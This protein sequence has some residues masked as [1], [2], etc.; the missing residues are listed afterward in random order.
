MT[1]TRE[2]DHPTAGKLNMAEVLA[3]FT[4]TGDCPLKFTAYDG[5][6]AGNED[7]V[8]GLD[9]CSPRGTT[10]LATAPGELGIARAYI[11]GDL[12]TYGVHPGDPYELLRMLADRVDFK[13]PSARTLAQVIR[14]IGIEHLV[15]I[16][17]PPQETPPRWRRV[18]DGLLHSKTRDAEAIHHHYDVSNTFYEWLLGPSMTYTCAVYPHAGATLEEAQENKYRLIFDK[19]RLAPGDRL[20]DVGCGWGGMVRY[21]ARHGV[22]AIGVTLSG[23]QAKWAQ[24][25]IDKDGLS[26]LAEV[27]HCDYRDVPEA[28]FDAVSSIGLTEHIG[29]KNYPA[30]FEFLKSKLRT[31]GLLLNHCITRHDNKQTSFAGGFTDR[32]VFPDGELTGSGRILTEVQESGFEVLHQENFRHHY[33][34]TLRDWCRNLVEHWDIAV[35]EV[36]L[37]IAKV[38]GL[39]MAA[40]RVAFEQNNLQLHHVLAAN[41]ERRGADSLPLRPWW[42]P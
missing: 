7:A 39:Y 11:A 18:A 27:R 15:P 40:S 3:I 29:V 34:M 5:S 16:P 2:S 9:L 38:W 31:G 24:Q 23:E 22:R 30:Y 42:Q 1:T 10:Y 21:A 32:Y 25:A 17:P 35:A 13:R 26:T 41:V 8:L 14:S 20:L 28:E 37:P 12:Q 6:T 36:S 33:A 19:L 4:A